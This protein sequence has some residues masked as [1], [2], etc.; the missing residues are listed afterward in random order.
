MLRICLGKLSQ[1]FWKLGNFYL[2]LATWNNKTTKL[3]QKKSY[4]CTHASFL[5][6]LWKNENF[7]N[8]N[9]TFNIQIQAPL[10]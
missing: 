2:C 8:L 6:F 10:T 5:E 3:L 4:I 9:I 1:E 7:E